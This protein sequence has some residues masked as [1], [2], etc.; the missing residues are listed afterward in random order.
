MI[1][2]FLPTRS[3]SFAIGKGDLRQYDLHLTQRRVLLLGRL[4]RWDAALDQQV[5]ATRVRNHRRT[6]EKAIAPGMVCVVMRVD[7]ITHRNIQFMFDELTDTKRLIW[8]SQR[9]DHHRPLRTCHH[10]RC[11]LSIY[12]TLEPKNIFRNSFAMHS[13]PL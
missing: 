12:F 1:K 4:Q 7:H 8:Q 2:F 9:I 5:A 13:K 3:V 6:G 11:Y 10:P